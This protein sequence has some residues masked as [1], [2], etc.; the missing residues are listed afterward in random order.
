LYFTLNF[1]CDKPSFT[2]IQKYG[3]HTGIT[4]PNLKCNLFSTEFFT[5]ALHPSPAGEMCILLRACV[6]ILSFCR[7]LLVKKEVKKFT[8][9]FCIENHGKGEAVPLQACAGP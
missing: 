9:R 7:I 5:L 3:F 4:Y 6:E 8:E 1:L 2:S